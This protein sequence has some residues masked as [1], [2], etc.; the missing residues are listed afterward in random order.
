MR[1]KHYLI[2]EQDQTERLAQQLTQAAQQIAGDCA[3]YLQSIADASGLDNNALYR[4]MQTSEPHVERSVRKNRKPVDMPPQLHEFLD[5]WFKDKF[6]VAARSNGLFVSTGEKQ[7]SNYGVPY[8]VFPKGQF[9]VIASREV[10][11]LFDMLNQLIMDDPRFADVSSLYDMG[12][13]QLGKKQLK[14]LERI[15]D[16]AEY[17]QYNVKSLQDEVEAVVICDSYHAINST[18]NPHILDHFFET[19]HNQI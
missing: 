14:V 5:Q 2:N 11:D 3:P 12:N 8:F 6:G 1:F 18:I 16:Q 4:G 19:L 7:A 15:L 13:K 10:R 17:K 9:S